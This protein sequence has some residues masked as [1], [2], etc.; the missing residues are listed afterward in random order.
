MD[1][2]AFTAVHHAEWNRLKQ[3]S[4]Q[5]RLSGE[6]ADELL[7]LYQ[8]TSTHLS[9]I[10]SVSVEGDL[11]A[12]LSMLLARTRTAFTGA[13]S[14][15]FEDVAVFCVV[16]LPAAFYRLR[17]LT[18][19]IAAGFVLIAGLYGWWVAA[20]PEVQSAL[21]LTPQL[22]DTFE[23]R[24]VNY[25]S[26]N[27]AASFAGQ[28]WTNNAWIAAQCVAFGVTG[29]WPL[30]MIYS[31]AQGVGTTAGVMFAYGRGDVF[32]SYILPHGLME[33]TAIFVAAAAGFRLFWAWVSPGPLRRAQSLAQ[34]GR[35]LI[36]VALGLLVVL[37]VSGVV[38]AFVTPSPLPV[39]VK[40]SI[41]A[42][43]LAGYW[44]YTLVLGARAH[45]SGQHGDLAEHDA[46]SVV[47]TA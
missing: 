41:G 20:N 26:E 4:G 45:R 10:R 19:V 28:V 9:V 37:L 39:W 36:T 8:V 27:P 43:V 35:S 3:L 17:W 16:S 23:G 47:P 29:I 33:L 34:E 2:D 11:S 21:G 1:L 32:F 5:S 7:R 44:A 25:Y 13:R 42:L 40:I 38:E 15:I 31:N 46:G 22:K 12:R 6:E 18:L 24:F 30:Y 14:N